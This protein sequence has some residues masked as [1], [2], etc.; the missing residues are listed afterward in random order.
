MLLVITGVGLLIHVYSVGYMEHDEGVARFFSYMN[1]FIFSMALLVL[2][3]NLVILIIGWAAV[4]LSSYLLI[5]FWYERE[6]AVLAARKAFITQVIGDVA[7]VIAAFLIF[8]NLTHGARAPA[9]PAGVR[10]PAAPAAPPHPEPA[11][12]LRQRRLAGHGQPADHPD[13]HPARGRRPSPRAPSSPSTPG[14]PTPWRA[15]PRSRP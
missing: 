3:A 11:P 8:V 1:F 7:L 15:P 4:A 6:S 12:D 10:G 14:C 2:A 9:R 5:G 13:L